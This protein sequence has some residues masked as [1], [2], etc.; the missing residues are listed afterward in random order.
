MAGPRAPADLPVGALPLF[1]PVPRGPTRSTPPAAPNLSALL[2]FN[3]RCERGHEKCRALTRVP[4]RGRSRVGGLTLMPSEAPEASVNAPLAFIASSDRSLLV[5]RN[6]ADARAGLIA[7]NVAEL[8]VSALVGSASG[9]L[10][11]VY[12]EDRASCE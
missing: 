12:R 10:G 5:Q 7:R 11:V 4:W 8:G 1:T 3:M 9:V 2:N 6:A